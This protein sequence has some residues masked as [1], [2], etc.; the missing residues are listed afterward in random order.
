MALAVTVTVV[1]IER[2][3]RRRGRAQ[4]EVVVKSMSE[5]G[6]SPFFFERH[7]FFNFKR[8][9]KNEK[10]FLGVTRSGAWKTQPN[11]QGHWWYVVLSIEGERPTAVDVRGI[12][13][14]VF[15]FNVVDVIGWDLGALMFC[16]AGKIIK[17]IFLLVFLIFFNTITIKK[18]FY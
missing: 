10:E 7:S 6:L 14:S 15:W 17:T 2:E 5:N 18:G 1:V 11:H 16:L 4:R 12:R 3:S 8:N 9:F 13:S